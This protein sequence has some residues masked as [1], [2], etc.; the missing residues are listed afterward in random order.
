MGVCLAEAPQGT[1][2]R[3]RGHGQRHGI[4]RQLEDGHVS[5]LDPPT[6]RDSKRHANDS[7]RVVADVTFVPDKSTQVLVGKTTY[8][9]GMNGFEPRS[10]WIYAAQSGLRLSHRPRPGSPMPGP[11]ARC[12]VLA[13]GLL[14][15]ACGTP[16]TLPASPTRRS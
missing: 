5:L 7:A 2:R 14:V 11:S 4:F 13:P 1:A 15:F 3:A 12:V 8:T 16:S 6:R 9:P 10:G